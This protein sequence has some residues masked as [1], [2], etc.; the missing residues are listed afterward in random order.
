MTNE[1]V[2]E[3]APPTQEGSVETVRKVYA[4]DLREKDR[5]HT[6]FRVTKKEK[7]TARSGKV[8][9]A[10]TLV[11][12]SGEVDARVFDNVD[13][14]EPVFQPGDFVLVQGNVIQFHG[15]SQIVV[16][17]VERLDPE[18]LDPKEFEPPPAPPAAEAKPAPEAKAAPEAKPEK[19]EKADKG[20][21]RGNEGPGGARA[22]GL[23]REMV[24]E[25]IG[26]TFVKQLL[27]AF[28]D[29]PK[30]AAGLPVAQGARGTHHAWRGGLA[31][32]LLSVMRLTLRVADQYPMVDRDLLLAGAL[33]QQVM[34]AADAA[35]SSDEARLVGNLVLTAQK[36]REKAL[37]IPGFPPLLE[38][39]L[40][41]LV[42]SQHGD[43]QH[44]SPKSPVTLEAQIVHSLE[45]LDA[46]IASWLEAM[47]RDS[48]D[49]WTDVVR[50]YERQLWKGPSPTS[51]GRA[52]VEG[53]GGRRKGREEKRKARA[54]KPQ[55]PGTPAEGAPKQEQAQR[56]PRKERPPREERSREERPPRED[57]PPRPPREERPPRDASSLPKELTFKPFSA[58]TSAPPESGNKGGEG[59]SES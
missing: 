37:A 27:L 19:P 51:R 24:T 56:P 48:H 35:E 50:P 32:H 21:A 47:Q 40:T 36:L 15:R 12:K 20:E 46:R 4:A 53:G 3:S 58:L 16:E 29:D 44:G 6:V 22:A 1:N 13:A 26:D 59:S 38:Q 9:V 31:E 57:R 25:R 42:I 43:A 55:Q 28:L 8:F 54:E 52:P 33:L 2:P 45:S 5:V 17:A 41:H 39:H 11:D 7:V 49:K 14:L 34:K 18:P 10:A 30:I 23:I